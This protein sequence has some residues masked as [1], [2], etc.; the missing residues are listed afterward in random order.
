MTQS[1]LSS[2]SLQEKPAASAFATQSNGATQRSGG[3]EDN[4]LVS[5]GDPETE[6][7]APAAGHSHNIA[8]RL[9]TL[10]EESGIGASGS[11]Q[12]SARCGIQFAIDCRLTVSKNS[13]ISECKAWGDQFIHGIIIVISVS[14]FRIRFSPH[15]SNTATCRSGNYYL[16]L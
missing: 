9:Q 1:V 11:A 5:E 6:Q 3:M 8:Q 4:L 13:R 2:Q 15:V 14:W 7:T 10:R 12:P 16:Y